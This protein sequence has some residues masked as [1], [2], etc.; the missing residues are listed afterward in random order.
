[1]LEK[2]R[3]EK[4]LEVNAALKSQLEESHRTNEALTND[5]QKLGNDWEIL[6]EEMA[7][8]EEEWKEEES[9]FNE[10]Y[11]SE[12]NRLLNLWRDVVSLK[13]IFSEMKSTTERDLGKYHSKLSTLTNEMNTA[14]TSV[15]MSMKM[16]ASTSEQTVNTIKSATI[17]RPT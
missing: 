17:S 13:R 5:L 15:N 7:I 4:L 11:T 16:L 1:M 14:C 8:K 10:Y 2:R 6:R 9:A 3:S 12:H